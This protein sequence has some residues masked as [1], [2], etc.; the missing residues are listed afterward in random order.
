[1][2]RNFM[3]VRWLKKSSGSGKRTEQG[4]QSRSVERE[5]NIGW[6]TRLV[7]SHIDIVALL[8]PI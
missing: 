1:M 7:M 6:R 5:A 2:A 4:R 3:V 8:D